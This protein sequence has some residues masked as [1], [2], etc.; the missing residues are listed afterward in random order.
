MHT[1]ETQQ[2][3]VRGDVFVLRARREINGLYHESIG[4]RTRLCRPATI[5][6]EHDIR[7][8]NG[9]VA[10]LAWL[11]GKSLRPPVTNG[12]H[13]PR[14][15]ADRLV[16]IADELDAARYQ[17]TEAGLGAGEQAYVGGVHDALFWATHEG[18]APPC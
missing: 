5:H 12:L 16:C 11:L 8:V 2:I 4:V 10:A 1:M 9:I 3:R 18:A 6:E 17:V 13:I 15:D 7:R 14:N